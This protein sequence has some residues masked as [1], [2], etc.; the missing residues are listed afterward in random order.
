MHSVWT[1]GTP[2]IGG[3]CN[4]DRAAGCLAMRLTRE[5]DVKCMW[6]GEYVA[7]VDPDLCTGCRQCAELCPFDAIELDAASQKAMV[8]LERCYGCGVCRAACSAEALS[9]APR[10]DVPAV[11]RVW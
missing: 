11:A 3:L 7:H 5:Y 4:C 1:F 6:K 9:L 2:F 10:A 8:R